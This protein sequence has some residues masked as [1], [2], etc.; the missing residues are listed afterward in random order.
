MRARALAVAVAV[1]ACDQLVKVL[2]RTAMSEGERID[3]A[4]P[5]AIVSA[6]NDGVAFGALGGLPPLALVV[7]GAVVL[8]VL[9]FV[10]RGS[11]RIALWVSAGAIVGGAAGNIVD[12][13]LFGAVT[14][15]LKVS[16][17]PA[18]NVADAAIVCGGIA[19]VWFSERDRTGDDD[20]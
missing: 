11:T 17:W 15:Y 13:V 5:F 4:G 1:L 3:I 14:D 9:A 16:R 7:I 20:A 6:R 2:V 19:L 18:F 10:V 12:R 8:A